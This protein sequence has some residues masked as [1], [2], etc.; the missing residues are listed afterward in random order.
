MMALKG[1]NRE[2]LF[3]DAD[4]YRFFLQCLGKACKQHPVRLHAHTLLERQIFLL[5][6]A[7]DKT[8]LARF[9]QYLGR[10]YVPYFNRRHGRTGALWEGRYKSCSIEPDSYFLLCQKYMD[11]LAARDG[12]LSWSSSPAY[13]GELPLGFLSPHP[14]YLEL[15]SDAVARHAAYRQF[16][17]LPLA[18]SFVFRIEACL[19]QN[20]V[21]GTLNYCLKLEEQLL[22]PVRPRQSG[23]PRKHFPDRLQ[24]WLWLEQEAQS[25]IEGLA[26][27]EIR[28]PLLE[29]PD[30]AGGEMV[31]RSE[32]TMGCLTAIADLKL[33]DASARFWYQGPMFRTHHLTGHQVEQFH[34]IGAEAIGFPGLDIELEQLLLQHDLVQRLNLSSLTELQLNTLG[35][36]EELE[37]HRQCLRTYLVSACPDVLPRWQSILA[38]CPETLLLEGAG[39]PADL[40]ANA[41]SIRQSLS[42]A[43]LARFQH[44]SQALHA[45]GVPHVE[46]PELFPHRPFYQHTFYEWQSTLLE[47]SPVLCRGGR[48]DQLATR[49]TGRTT[50]AC[51]F[52]FMVEPLI[53]LAE[54][55]RSAPRVRRLHADI[56]VCSEAADSV[57]A[58]LLA[59]RL[60]TAFPYL[61]VINDYRRLRSQRQRHDARIVICVSRDGRHADIRPGDLKTGLRCV[62]DEVVFR[63]RSWLA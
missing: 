25:A 46:R 21:L 3:C 32:G 42:D 62:L 12:L 41:P 14:A 56:L 53:Q 47:A 35:S 24:Y 18:A 16:L 27:Q 54:K 30:A 31:L 63:L 36:P 61:S 38:R 58:M 59:Q 5:L 28:L 4:D 55:A 51:G 52:A 9:T 19:Q 20:C 6:S 49:I 60:R 29:S 34:Q 1:N 39:L 45:A 23:R 50:R 43:S 17:A 44:L 13:Q 57:A 37:R 40:R 7:E 2:A 15:A 48:Y 26:Y 33:A 22:Q 11:S 10:C 8:V